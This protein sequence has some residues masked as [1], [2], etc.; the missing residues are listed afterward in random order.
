MAA[1]YFDGSIGEAM[2]YLRSRQTT[3]QLDQAADEQNAKMLA[4]GREIAC[5]ELPVTTWPE[6]DDTFWRDTVS[7]QSRGRSRAG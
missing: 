1:K 6:D 5:T 7:S 2:A 3:Y 4:N